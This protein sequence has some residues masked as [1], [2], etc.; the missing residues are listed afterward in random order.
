MIL[1]LIECPCRGWAFRIIGILGEIG[2]LERN[3]VGRIRVRDKYTFVGVPEEKL[4]EI[5]AKLAG[6]AI[7]DR[8]LDAERARVTRA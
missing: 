8:P 6:C 5:V 3:E 1:S 7:N 2:G 4:D